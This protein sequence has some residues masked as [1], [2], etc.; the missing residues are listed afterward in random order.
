M[1]ISVRETGG[2]HILDFSGNFDTN[3]APIAEDEINSLLDAG[4]EK[5]LFNFNELNY[6]SSAGLRVLL[7]T[8]K[9]LKSSDGAMQVCNLNTVVQEVFDISGFA[10]ILSL[11][12]DEAEALAAF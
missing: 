5:I 12:S 1:D 9:K 11:A 6:I 8:A 2:V 7:T 4:S 10:G 3:T